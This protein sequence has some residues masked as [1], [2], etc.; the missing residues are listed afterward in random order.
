MTT[1]RAD[2]PPRRALED[3]T[4]SK[5]ASEPPEEL[6]FRGHVFAFFKELSAVVIGAI[7]VASLLRGFV[8]QMFLIPS[9]SME[10]TLKVNDRV[11]VEKLSTTKRGE[12]VVFKDP[13]GWL[14]G[15]RTPER[16]P[17]GKALQF[18]GVLPDTSTEHLIKRAVGLP[19]DHVVCCDRSGRITVNDQALDESSYLDVGADN[20][21]ARP[22]TIPFDVVV[23]D[24]RIFVLGDNR[25]HS[26]D[27]RCHLNDP[28]RDV[29][30][31]AFVSEDLV[32]GR[33][34]AVVWPFDRKHRL[35][36][37]ATFD[38][39]P[40]GKLPAPGTPQITAGPEAN[41]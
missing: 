37:P 41:C 29:G 33:A 4:R 28:G 5:D 2:G 13:G 35:Q 25:D 14:T 36:I 27:S 30:G 38:S 8:G 24:G 26:R 39:V 40:P 34:I 20:L 18:V 12:V 21:P 16:G 32:V 6:S 9:V 19:G 17:I 1:E 31:N 22:S 15:T 10:N 7:I 23:P 3:D 11:V